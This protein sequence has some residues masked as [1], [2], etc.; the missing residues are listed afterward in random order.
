LE[1]LEL[2]NDAMRLHTFH[3]AWRHLRSAPR[4]AEAKK[5]LAQVYAGAMNAS[6]L[7]GN[8]LAAFNDCVKIGRR[9]LELFPSSCAVYEQ[10][11]I[12]YS[13]VQ[14]PLDEAR[15][16]LDQVVRIG[17][18]T[19]LASGPAK[20]LNGQE[21]ADFC[22]SPDFYFAYWRLFRRDPDREHQ[23]AWS[24]NRY[25]QAEPSKRSFD[26]KL[27]DLMA[28]ERQAQIY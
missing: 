3:R 1:A 14:A 4:D 21:D 18:M 28:L 9:A 10:L 8:N 24:L 11:A 17:C 7:T 13:I 12:A 25:R 20:P 2:A 19:Q 22:P 26:A 27:R 23:V 6:C 16:C 5:A 15:R